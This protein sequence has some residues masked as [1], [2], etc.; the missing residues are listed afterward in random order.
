MPMQTR[1]L[2]T[3]TTVGGA[4]CS[5]FFS[6]FQKDYGKAWYSKNSFNFV[7]LYHFFH[8]RR[9][10]FMSSSSCVLSTQLRAA[11]SC[12]SRS[13]GPASLAGGNCALADMTRMFAKQTNEH[14]FN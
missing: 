13:T 4:F 14:K 5:L 2:I 6:F 8:P 1:L 7:F 11:T 3:G 10:I 12:C 9:S